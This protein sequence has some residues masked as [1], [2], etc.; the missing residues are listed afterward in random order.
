[1][2]L[3][4]DTRVAVPLP[5]AAVPR[6]PANVPFQRQ[7]LSQW[8]WA[9]CIAMV[10]STPSVTFRQCEAARLHVGNNP[11]PC[12]GSGS[13]CT[14]GSPVLG[15]ANQQC[16]RVA[17]I[18]RIAGLWNEALTRT[19]IVK[20]GVISES[21]LKLAL[22]AGAGHAVQV[23]WFLDDSKHVALIVGH[24]DGQYKVHD[25]CEGDYLLTYD[26]IVR[27]DSVRQWNAT[28]VL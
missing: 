2:P 23:L 1:M 16:N 15:D 21:T 8:C 7:F 26:E 19:D 18:S 10:R 17:P 25:P 11:D 4:S 5:F 27:V 6:I 28:W 14:S 20:Q 13:G 3:R 22:A 9:A 24:K 12:A